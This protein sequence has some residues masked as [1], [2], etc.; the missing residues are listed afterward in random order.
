MKHRR[1]RSRDVSGPPGLDQSVKRGSL[2]DRGLRDGVRCKLK[3]LGR[4]VFTEPLIAKNRVGDLLPSLGRDPT[5][6]VAVRSPPRGPDLGART[7]GDHRHSDLAGSR[8]APVHTCKR[9]Y[10]PPHRHQ[11]RQTG[12]AGRRSASRR[13]S[14]SSS[15]M[16]ALLSVDMVKTRRG[17]VHNCRISLILLK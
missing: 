7:T 15:A 1:V 11:R 9:R 12:M 4:I 8:S 16:S 2:D 3:S 14:C 13:C 5:E 10:H 6:D 17:I